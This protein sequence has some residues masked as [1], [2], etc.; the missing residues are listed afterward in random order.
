MPLERRSIHGTH[1]SYCVLP[2]A[3]ARFVAIK[4]HGVSCLHDRSL[5]GNSAPNSEEVYHFTRAFRAFHTWR[6][7][8]LLNG[9]LA[10]RHGSQ[11]RPVDDVDPTKEMSGG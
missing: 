8:L 1:Q 2:A 3:P 11:N 5:H 6:V 4:E 10:L 9:L 7:Q